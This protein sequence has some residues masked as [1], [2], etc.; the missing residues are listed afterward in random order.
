MGQYHWHP[1]S[2]W[3]ATWSAGFRYPERLRYNIRY[4]WSTQVTCVKTLFVTKSMF[5]GCDWWSRQ[6]DIREF[7]GRHWMAAVAHGRW[8]D[9]HTIRAWQIKSYSY[10][11]RYYGPLNW[12]TH[13][14]IFSYT[15][16]CYNW[17]SRRRQEVN[18]TACLYV[19][20][21]PEKWWTRSN[22][23]STSCPYNSIC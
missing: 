17:R 8:V 23:E 19:K 2:R 9:F 16:I 11:Q 20:R 7:S 22:F 12:K 13:K 5:M 4:S 6:N 21:K 18:I 3:N 1:S 14:E 10:V 15:G